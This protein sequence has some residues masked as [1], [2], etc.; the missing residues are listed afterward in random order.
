MIT[1]FVLFT[2]LTSRFKIGLRI[3]YITGVLKSTVDKNS[4]YLV[5]YKFLSLLCCY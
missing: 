5:S 1:E 4:D 2:C 3:C